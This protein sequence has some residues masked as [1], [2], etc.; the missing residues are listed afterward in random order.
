MDVADVR[1]VRRSP[2][3]PAVLASSDAS[4]RQPRWLVV[5]AAT[6]V[7]AGIVL[8]FW[9]TS[10]LWLDEA[11]TVNIAR[12]PLREIPD[13]LR[14]DGAP[15]LYYFLLHGWI[16]L[17][18]EGDAAVRALSGLFGV[19]A[20]PVVWLAGRKL[21]G[22]QV[23]WTAL[24]LLAT[25]PFG[26]RFSTETRMYALVTLLTLVGYL[27]LMSALDS[28]T[29][30][31]LVAVGVLTGLLLLTHYWAIYLL[32]AAAIPLFVIARSPP[33]RAGGNNDRSVAA[34]RA[35]AAIAGGCVL[36]LP[37][38]PIFLGQLRH[39]G[40]P[41][42][43]PPSLRALVNALS[44]FAGGV[45]SA[46]R[47]LA[48]V[49]FAL[50]ALALFG[51]AIDSRHIELDLHTRPLGRGLAVVIAS[52]LLIAVGIGIATRSAY[53][54]RY[55]AVVFGLFILFIALGPTSF[56]DPRVR[57]SIIAVAMVAGLWGASD[58]ITEQ[59]TQA[60]DLAAA[61]TAES[62]RGDVVGYCP[63][64]LGPGVS[65]L[66][67]DGFTQLTY[68]R[69]RPPELVDWVDYAERLERA[70][71]RAFGDLLH[72]R[73]GSGHDVFLVF[74]GDYRTHVD[75]C[76]QIVGRLAELRNGRRVVKADPEAFYE[77]AELY[78]FQPR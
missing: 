60:G 61:I 17:F 43:D 37:W 23:A 36:F 40:T 8:R 2:E 20:F 10:D 26:I 19:A 41:W 11:L 38:V 12:L 75:V 62:R 29:L 16:Q 69:A 77:H 53:A 27:A 4:R 44:E 35:I 52:T 74:S 24:L 33:A 13:A 64:Q 5:G 54:S 63:D 70:D 7:I 34:R 30:P 47:G 71:P 31:R 15:P 76:E 72:E 18:G 3:P 45:T 78:R 39:T 67:G 59:R 25:S 58:N 51:R 6:A 42:G 14:H 57:C 73:A 68:A 48:V 66:L 56:A 21:A 22:R 50:A 65:R 9:T 49:I 1:T 32:T 55:T 28:P 46:G